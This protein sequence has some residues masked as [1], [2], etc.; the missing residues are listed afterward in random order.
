L[1]VAVAIGDELSPDEEAQLQQQQ[2]E[3]AADEAERRIPV[4]EE[5]LAGIQQTLKSAKDDA[6]RLRSQAEKGR[7]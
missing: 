1:T 3:E 5:K 4:I 7:D 2:R 6:K